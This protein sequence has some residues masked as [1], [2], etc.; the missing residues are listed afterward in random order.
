MYPVFAPIVSPL[1]TF[2]FILFL[3]TYNIIFIGFPRSSTERK[4]GTDG[5][6]SMLVINICYVCL[7]KRMILDCMLIVYWNVG[8]S[9]C[10]TFSLFNL[11]P[12]QR[13]RSIYFHHPYHNRHHRNLP[14]TNNVG[15]FHDT[16]LFLELPFF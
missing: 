11:T 3:S 15:D 14:D 7:E 4:R 9:D 1:M 8:R 2:A 13:H 16:C 6:W 12:N 5:Q 10:I